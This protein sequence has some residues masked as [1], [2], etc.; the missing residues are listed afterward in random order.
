MVSDIVNVA[1]ILTL[2]DLEDETKASINQYIRD[3]IKA[4]GE[5]P[6]KPPDLPPDLLNEWINGQGGGK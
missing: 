6:K 5:V 4:L 1:E 2:P 3:R